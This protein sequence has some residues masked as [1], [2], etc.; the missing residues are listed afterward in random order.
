LPL[1]GK[2]IAMMGA[3]GVMG[4]VRAQLHLRQILLHNGTLILPK[5]EVYIGRGWEKFDGE[6]NLID[7]NSKKQVLALLEAL[8]GWILRVNP[9]TQSTGE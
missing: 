7:E 9:K 3:G 6:G 4:T 2:P 5:P 1:N 8:Q